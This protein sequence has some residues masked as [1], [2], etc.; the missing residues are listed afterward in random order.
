[1]S[2]VTLAAASLTHSF[3]KATNLARHLEMIRDAAERGVDLVVFPEVGLQGYPDLGAP[4][5]SNERAE[6][7]Q[8][9]IR[10]AEPVPGPATDLIGEAAREHGI[11]VQ[12]GLAESSLHGNAIFN[13]AVLI[14]PNGL[15]GTY[16]KIHNQFEFPYFSPGEDTPVFDTPVGRVASVI[17]YDLCF[18]E[19]IR[20]YALHGAD[21]ILM[22]TAWPMKG[23]ERSSDY[24][25][26]AMDASARANAFFNHLWV[27]IANYCGG[28]PRGSRYYGGSQIV[29]PFGNV[30]AYLADEEGLLVHSADLAEQSLAA[31]T[32]GFFGLNLLQDRRPEHYAAVVDASY[33]HPSAVDPLPP[34]E[35]GAP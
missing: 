15:V 2:V 24:H 3:D 11:H 18:P 1:M 13:T 29:D 14:G 5:G 8:Y 35:G 7:R 9:F 16:R 20:A 33:R 28:G 31:R 21:V 25:G 17:C 19:L 32:S 27:V 26:W 23:Q 4:K 30:A 6:Q 34:G 10:E 12:I 22:S